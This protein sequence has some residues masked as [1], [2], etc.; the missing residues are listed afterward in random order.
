MDLRV[1]KPALGFHDF[2]ALHDERTSYGTWSRPDVPLLIFADHSFPAFFSPQATFHGGPIGSGMP[3]QLVFWGS[4]W[5]SAAGA[6]QSALIIDRTQALI[7]SNYFSELQ[8]YGVQ[9]PTWRGAIVVTEPSP[10]SAFTKQEHTQKVWDLIDDLID[11][12]KF[13]DPDEGRIA[14]VV[15]MPQGFTQSIGANGAH[16][17]DTDYDFPLDYDAFW[18][19]WV[20][21]FGPDPEAT[22]ITLAHELVEM[23]TDPEIDGWYINIPGQKGEEINDGSASAGGVRQTAWVN[24]AQVSSYWSNRHLA[25]VIP[26]D[27]DYAAQ[28]K[29]VTSEISR[30]VL[31]SGTFRPEPS[32]NAACE[33]V[34]E[35]CIEDRDYSWTVYGFDE[36]AKIRLSTSRYR[37]PK[38]SW[39]IEGVAVTAS[40]SLPL[41]LLVGAFTGRTAVGRTQ[42]VTVNYRCADEFLVIELLGSACN[43]DIKIACS[44]T[45]A[46]I[47]G[48]LKTNVVATPSLVVGFVG[49]QLELDLA[50][51]RQRTACF[52]ALIAA[53]N[54]N[55]SRLDNVPGPGDPIDQNVLAE[56]PAY[57]RLEQYQQARQALK[58]V[59]MARKLLKED[60][61]RAYAASLVKDVPTLSIATAARKPQQGVSPRIR[62]SEGDTVEPPSFG[63]PC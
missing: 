49:A 59:G 19:A 2:T 30:N 33:R 35:C 52:S 54:V 63:E 56:L 31:S 7:A 58:L 61:A 25:N 36:R 12:D 42:L 51:I 34:R 11:D 17:Y 50:Y 55:Y 60:Q 13:P 3:V 6:A 57:A 23:F 15:L 32:D 10:P 53:Y 27:R 21:Y 28:L 20:R 45:D 40:G 8:Q 26:I 9:R 24:G 44:V 14:F 4:W 29:A 37:Q 5:I 38:A 47:T 46:S 48:N 43:F 1:F 39:S 18:A 62:L 22:I 16:Y 41:T